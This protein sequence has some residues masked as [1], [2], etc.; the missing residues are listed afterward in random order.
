MAAAGVWRAVFSSLAWASARSQASLENPLEARL[1]ARATV[2]PMRAFGQGRIV[3]STAVRVTLSA[4]LSLGIVAACSGKVENTGNGGLGVSMGETGGAGGTTAAAGGATGSVSG[5]LAGSMAGAPITVPIAPTS[6]P[7]NPPPSRPPPPSPSVDAGAGEPAGDG[8]AS[9]VTFD[10]GVSGQATACDGTAADAPC[11][12]PGALCWNNPGE[13][14]P[15]ADVYDPLCTCMTGTC[16]CWGMW[17]MDGPPY[18]NSSATVCDSTQD[19]TTCVTTGSLCWT[20]NADVA[21]PCA[22]YPAPACDCDDLPCRCWAEPRSRY[23]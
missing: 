7:S 1:R 13:L 20:V 21:D 15:C 6:T 2:G 19:T 12:E 4:A 9:A 3:E 17:G 22:N 8:D 10:A 14:V 18:P 23:Q 16:E 11:L 5:G